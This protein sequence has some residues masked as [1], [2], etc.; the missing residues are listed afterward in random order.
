LLIPS[1]PSLFSIPFLF[2]LGLVLQIFV[3]EPINSDDGELSCT[4]GQWLWAGM[5]STHCD[6]PCGLC[7]TCTQLREIHQLYGGRALLPDSTAEDKGLGMFLGFLN[8][9][10]APNIEGE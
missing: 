1:H 8:C 2:S 5:G 10:K 4:S 7:K 3:N 6:V 9:L